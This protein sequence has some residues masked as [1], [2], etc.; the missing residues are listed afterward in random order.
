METSDTVI[1]TDR[2]GKHYRL[3]E[4]RQRV[5]TLRDAVHQTAGRLAQSLR[6]LLSSRSF[7]QA[8]PARAPGVWA[9]KDVSLEV[10]R[11]EVLGVI[12]GNGAGKST[13][14]KILSRITEPTE[15][16]AWVRGRVGSL[17]EVGTG[18]HS[19]LTGRENLYLSGA[20]LGMRRAEIDRKFDEIVAFAEVEPFLDTPVKHYSS[21]QY[22]R[23][24]FAVAA[25]LEPE[26]LFVDEVL[27][28]GDAAFQRKCLGK[29]G[30]VARHGRT[31]LFVSHNLVAVEGLCD[32]VVWLK[33]G[34]IARQGRPG[35][36][37]AEY[38]AEAFV[39]LAEQVWDDANHLGQA[40]GN[41]R[42][43]L[44]RAA[45]R[46][47]GGAPGDPID[48][49]TPFAVEVEYQNLQPG[50]RLSLSLL[51]FEEGGVLLF[52]AG[53]VEESPWYGQPFPAGIYR[54]V[55]H[56]PGDLLNNGIHRVDVLLIQDQT[57]VVYRHGELLVFEVRDSL[58]RRGGWFGTWTG[59]TRPLL[60]WSTERLDAPRV[61]GREPEVGRGLSGVR[62]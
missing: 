42:V 14:L 48:V 24:A 39:P 56:I 5:N 7:S 19:E 28:V 52:N 47:E 22:L 35:P 36:V 27:A 33:D 59:V 29:M 10:T 3:G 15:G 57:R 34:R 62:R 32:R 21:G 31:V 30:D 51:L 40:P 20:I 44:R 25:H 17:L 23:L 41:E 8:G 38:L 50:A 45:V 13:L 37:V 61:S 54:D 1:R 12:G 9:L 18:F 58:E 2:L 49:R 46:P 55:C 11:G 6:S 53:P 60:P 4:A 26:I 16:E 43:R